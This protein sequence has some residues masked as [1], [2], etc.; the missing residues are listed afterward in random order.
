[1]RVP[2]PRLTRRRAVTG[3]V[4]VA[5]LAGLVAWAA[6]PNAPTYT[7]TARTITVRT[8]P[9]GTTPIPL[10][11]TYYQPDGARAA[12]ARVRRH[13]GQRRLRCAGPGRPRVRG[14]HVDRRG[15]RGERRPD[16]LRQPRL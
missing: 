11:T 12:R 10:D 5:L 2:W 4:V 14:A 7:A 16:P 6:W 9:D 1:M 8:G 3:A 15:L 13:E